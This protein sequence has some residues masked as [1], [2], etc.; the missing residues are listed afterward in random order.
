MISV[1]HRGAG[2][3]DTP[4]GLVPV[5]YALTVNRT[6]TVDDAYGHVQCKGANFARLLNAGKALPLILEEA[7]RVHIVLTAVEGDR[8]T[9]ATTGS[10]ADFL[11]RQ[12]K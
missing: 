9:F 6:T 1:T 4:D 11:F 2:Q 3:L 12:I 8:A 5:T 10:I 7:G